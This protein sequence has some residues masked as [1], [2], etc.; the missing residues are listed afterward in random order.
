MFTKTNCNF[1]LIH[2]TYVLSDRTATSDVCKR[3]SRS[4]F[5]PCD[6]AATQMHRSLWPDCTFRWNDYFRKWV[7]ASTSN[8]SSQKA[9]NCQEFEASTGYRDLVS[10]IKSTIEMFKFSLMQLNSTW[11]TNLLLYISL[12]NFLLY[13]FLTIKLQKSLGVCDICTQPHYL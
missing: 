4:A 10:T 13:I 12:T 1:L 5:W 9:K 7:L 2:K 3:L 11:S 6:T 8:C